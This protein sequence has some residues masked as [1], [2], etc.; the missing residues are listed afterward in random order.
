M[1]TEPN[2]HQT[3]LALQALQAIVDGFRT[4][5][6]GHVVRFGGAMT[7]H[8][9]HLRLVLAHDQDVRCLA[10]ALGFTASRTRAGVFRAYG[11]WLGGHLTVS[12]VEKSS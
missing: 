12:S 11:P 9:T 10:D 3:A 2:H 8:T 1:S 7:P 6:T 5:G 4:A